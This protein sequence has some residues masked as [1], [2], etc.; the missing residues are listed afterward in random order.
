ML[1]SIVATV[2]VWGG[3][4]CGIAPA[5]IATFPSSHGHHRSPIARDRWHPHL[6]WA[7]PSRSWP[8]AL[9][10]GG[11]VGIVVPQVSEARP[12][13][14]GGFEWRGSHRRSG[15]VD[16]EEDLRGVIFPFE[17]DFAGGSAEG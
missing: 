5:V 10:D 3:A 6:I 12:G 13:A 8:S 15:L 9:I 1:A 7:K 16:G 14:P 2:R 17:G 11:E 4:G